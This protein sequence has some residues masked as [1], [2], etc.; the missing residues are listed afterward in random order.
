LGRK[1]SAALTRLDLKA[2]H[3]AS[4]RL[5]IGSS[6][7][8]PDDRRRAV[9]EQ[10]S[11]QN[12]DPEE[13]PLRPRRRNAMSFHMWSSRVSPMG[14]NVGGSSS[15]QPEESSHPKF[16]SVGGSQTARACTQGSYCSNYE[17]LSCAKHGGAAA[18]N[19]RSRERVNLPL[20][21]FLAGILLAR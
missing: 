4:S 17:L 9:E 5:E 21:F 18:N 1:V 15:H 8:H 13:Y 3:M 11:L 7:E 6:S 10:D 2:T 16:T 12:G 14:S 20:H 19:S